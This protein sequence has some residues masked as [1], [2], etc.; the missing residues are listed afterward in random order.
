MTDCTHI[1]ITLK[2]GKVMCDTCMT[3]DV[4]ITISSQG[5]TDLLRYVKDVIITLEKGGMTDTAGEVKKR[6]EGLVVN[7][8]M[9]WKDFE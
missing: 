4:P 1:K 2:G 3:E 5:L 8:Q 6:S 9:T 7:R